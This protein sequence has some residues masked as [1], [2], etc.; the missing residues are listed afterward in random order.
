VV[1]ETKLLENMVLAI[2]PRVSLNNYLYGIEDMVLVT[3][4][5]GVPLTKFPLTPLEI[6]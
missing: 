5:G 3:G 4:S 6:E 2:E 1:E